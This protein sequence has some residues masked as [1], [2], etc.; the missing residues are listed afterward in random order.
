MHADPRPRQLR[1]SL[2]V[3]KIDPHT[4]L[5]IRIAR[6]SVLRSFRWASW[7]PTRERALGGGANRSEWE[8]EHQPSPAM[9][10]FRKMLKRKR[11]HQTWLGE[12]ALRH[13]K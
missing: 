6:P 8:S 12:M 1:Q 10:K 2:F 9:L 7:V 3:K 5:W 13:L 4:R 11:A